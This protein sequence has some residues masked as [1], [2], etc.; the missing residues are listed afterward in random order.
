[1]CVCVCVYIWRR[2]WQSTPVFLPEKSM[3]RSLAG[4]PVHNIHGESVHRVR[5]M[6][7]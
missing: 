6:W 2:K 4:F 1:M 3:E 5:K 7:T